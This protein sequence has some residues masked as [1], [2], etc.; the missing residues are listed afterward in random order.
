MADITL[1]SSATATT[2]APSAATDGVALP[3]CTDRAV[4]FAYGAC[5]AGQTY[6][7]TLKMWGYKASLAKWF[8]MGIDATAANKGLINGGS[9]L[10]ETGTD[11]MAH[12]EEL[13][14]LRRFDR[15]ACQVTAIS[16]TGTEV[17]V[18]LSCIPASAVSQ[19]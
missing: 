8:P 1:L 19:S 15:V 16:G 17:S 7:V 18:V 2:S 14:A 9:A 13:S 5:T 6:S 12:C 4:L 11:L 3:G 10:G